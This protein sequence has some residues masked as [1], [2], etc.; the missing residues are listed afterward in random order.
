VTL[1][2]RW[3]ISLAGKSVEVGGVRGATIQPGGPVLLIGP[4]GEATLLVQLNVG[5]YNAELN[6]TTDFVTT[7]VYLERVPLSMLTAAEK[8][9]PEG[10]R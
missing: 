4:T 9:M 5:A 1:V 10:A 8:Q 6:V 3:D 2:L 7:T